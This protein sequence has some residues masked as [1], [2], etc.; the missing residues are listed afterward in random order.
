MGEVDCTV[1]YTVDV[2]ETRVGDSKGSVRGQTGTL[3][4]IVGEE[5]SCVYG[6]YL[7]E[8]GEVGG[9]FLEEGGEEGGGEEAGDG[10]EGWHFGLW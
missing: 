5:P 8:G 6:D 3:L 10:G 4:G 7:G 1:F 2:E 9:C